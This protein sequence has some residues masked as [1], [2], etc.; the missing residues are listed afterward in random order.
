MRPAAVV[1]WS[2]RNSH[3]V[4]SGMARL[5]ITRDMRKLD[6]TPSPSWSSGA[7]FG[8]ESSQRQ[9]WLHS[10]ADFSVTVLSQ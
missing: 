10:P 4:P 2:R 5:V 1:I 8:A 6:S 7:A 3:R 9:T